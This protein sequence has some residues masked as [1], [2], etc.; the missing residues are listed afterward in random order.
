MSKSPKQSR[1]LGVSWDCHH[2]K[3]TARL[4]HDGTRVL[5]Q[6][7]KEDQE[8]EAA[9]VYDMY[10]RRYHGDGAFVNFDMNGNFLDP[11]NRSTRIDASAGVDKDSQNM[12]FRGVSWSKETNKWYAQIRVA[13]RTFNLG[14][15]SDVKAAAL[16]YDMAARKYHGTYARCNFDLQGNRTQVRMKLNN[17]AAAKVKYTVRENSDKEDENS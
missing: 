16:Q 11:K 13:G 2:K 4:Y 3:W 15:F 14:Y 7:F 8:E 12:D 10:A 6:T 1:F 9:L 17:S 5:S